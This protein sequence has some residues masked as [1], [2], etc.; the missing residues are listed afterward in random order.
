MYLLFIRLA[1]WLMVRSGAAFDGRAFPDQSE[2][3]PG[4]LHLVLDAKNPNRPRMVFEG[5]HDEALTAH[6]VLIG[7][8]LATR[9]RKGENAGK[10]LNHDFVVLAHQSKTG[11]GAWEF[12]V[13]DVNAAAEATAIAGWLSLGE[14]GV[15]IQAVAGW[16]KPQ[17]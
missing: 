4:N 11:T 5:D 14:N 6:L 8:G 9:V 13:K 15:P 3:S 17:F 1:H 2:R 7:T 10:T 12:E 16:L